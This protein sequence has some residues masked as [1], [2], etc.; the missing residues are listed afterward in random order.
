MKARISR[1]PSASFATLPC[2]ANRTQPSLGLTAT[3]VLAIALTACLT[4]CGGGS[5]AGGPDDSAAAVGGSD[6][7]AIPGSHGTP[8]VQPVPGADFDAEANRLRELMSLPDHVITPKIPTYNPITSAKIELGRHLFYDRRL[9]GNGTQSCAD[10]HRQSAAFSDNETIP[11]GSTRQSLKRN[12]QALVNLA[13]SPIL[14]WGHDGF[15]EI[16]QQLAVPLHADDPVELGILDGIVEEVLGRFAGDPLYQTLFLDAFPDQGGVMNMTTVK[17]ALAS[18][19]R[20]LVSFDSPYDRYIRGDADA[21]TVQQKRGLNLFF[22]H[23]LECSHCHTGINFTVAYEDS[24]SG[25]PS[26]G[27]MFFNTGLYNVDGAGSFPASD[28]GLYDLTLNPQDR[29]RFRAQGLRNVEVTGPYMH[30]G[31]LRTLR[32]VVRHYARGGREILDGPDAGDGRL[33]PLKSGLVRGFAISEEELDALVAFLE[34]LTDTSFLNNP[35]FE[36]PFTAD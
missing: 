13:W 10:C 23:R 25:T 27:G 24:R 18:F 3:A 30:D 4:A 16:E 28:Q 31:S 20:A 15:T 22:S 34:S 36:N 17:H 7:P 29:G 14:T 6:R 9:S 5:D 33:S 21:L 26:L 12:S 2:R 1:A 35:D 11:A 8:A 32:E 19:T